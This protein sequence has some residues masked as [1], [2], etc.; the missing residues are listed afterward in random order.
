MKTRKKELLKL[1]LA[2]GLM[3]APLLCH[4]YTE[5]KV[6]INTSAGSS[7]EFYIADNP[8]ITYQNNWLMIEND[9][10]VTVSVEAAD[11]AGFNFLPS[12]DTAIDD[13]RAEGRFGSMMS[14]LNAGSTVSV[15]ALDGK[16]IQTMSAG[17][18]GKAEIDFNQLPKGV[19]I[20]KTDKGSF[21]IQK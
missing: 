17:S 13:V 5:P 8:R 1:L 16:T 14:G 12:D 15:F 11:V 10:G 18:D 7:F 21:K 2:C 19:Y 20:I 6:V 4:A 3:M 9:K